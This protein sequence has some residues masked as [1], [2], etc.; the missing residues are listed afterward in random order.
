M[1]MLNR[2]RP[3]VRR[4][5]A[6]LSLAAFVDQALVRRVRLVLFRK[7][8]A[9]AEAELWFSPIV[10]ARDHA[11]IEFATEALEQLRGA[12]A[13]DLA[14][15]EQARNVVKQA[16]R[17]AA[18]TLKLE[19]ELI[20]LSVSGASNEL[21]EKELGRAIKA[22]DERP[23]STLARWAVQALPRFPERARST[24]AAWALALGASAR[25]GSTAAPVADSPPE[26]TLSWSTGVLPAS[27]AKV[28]VGVRLLTNG[29]ELGPADAEHAH[30]IAIP[31]TVPRFL[32]IEWTEAAG[33]ADS[34]A[35]TR[36]IAWNPQET[37]REIGPSG[38]VCL[39]TLLGERFEL[40]S[41]AEPSRTP[42]VPIPP[43]NHD[44]L[45]D[46][47]NEQLR[48][49]LREGTVIALVAAHSNT[50]AAAIE[51]LVRLPFRHIVVADSTHRFEEAHR[52]VFGAE[53]TVAEFQGLDSLLSI[54]RSSTN[55]NYASLTGQ[56]RLR[57]P[58]VFAALQESAVLFV[59]FDDLS[60]TVELPL[61]ED[62]VSVW[63]LERRRALA[64]CITSAALDARPQSPVQVL[65]FLDWYPDSVQWI[66]RLRSMPT[67]DTF[68]HVSRTE[69]CRIGG[70]QRLE[71]VPE[72]TS[73][74]LL[75]RSTEAFLNA[76]LRARR[77]GSL[78]ALAGQS[79][80]WIARDPRPHD[81]A[82]P[83][84]GRWGGLPERD[85]RL[86]TAEVTREGQRYRIRL[87]VSATE[88]APT[89][90]GQVIFHL[91][92]T[93][94]NQRRAVRVRDGRAVLTITVWGWFTVG[95]ECDDGRTRLELDLGDLP[96][97]E[98]TA[99][100]TQDPA[101]QRC[102]ISY[103]R[104][105]AELAQRIREV[106]ESK[107]ATVWLDRERLP[108]Q[109]WA[110]EVQ[111][112]LEICTCL[113]VLLSEAAAESELVL[114]EVE[115]FRRR[116]QA[117]SSLRLIPVRIGHTKPLAYELD[118]YLGN[119]QHASWN[120]PEDDTSLFD[121]LRRALRIE[122][123]EPVASR[124]AAVLPDLDNAGGMVSHD[125]PFY[126]TRPADQ[127][128]A[129]VAA[130]TGQTIII[131]APNEFGKSSA[132]V[133]YCAKCRE[134][135]QAVVLLDLTPLL[136]PRQTYS[137]FLA[138]FR[139]AICSSLEIV[140]DRDE[141]SGPSEL[142]HFMTHAVLAKLD[143]PLVIALDE[144]DAL[145]R[146]DF[147]S[148]F[149]TLLRAF[150]NRR[151]S[152]GAWE[153]LGLALTLTMPPHQLI[154]DPSRSPFNIGFSLRL[155][156]FTL[157]DCEDLD[158]RHSRPLGQP[159]VR[160]IFDLLSGHP[161]LT[162]AA[163][164]FVASGKG[165]VD[166][167]YRVALQSAGPFGMHLHRLLMVV[168]REK[169][170]AGLIKTLVSGRRLKSGNQRLLSALEANGIVRHDGREWRLANELY[171]RF[172]KQEL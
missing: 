93:F 59:G 156:S 40:S 96:K 133:R 160:Q 28:E 22:M 74:R 70:A 48:K 129:D 148:E 121:Q 16:H 110:R 33:T 52:R 36:T 123:A 139:S 20:W 166:D 17:H 21:I 34:R 58:D 98:A 51:R 171:A 117:E 27:I 82:D 10:V 60:N 32:E 42:A 5:A 66:V 43:P 19:E 2:L 31:A 46:V 155:T 26:G 158:N 13:L 103:H 125:N 9:R 85:G 122:F 138:Q 167:L 118:T 72:Q 7:L 127:D 41:V 61:S 170:S 73:H 114:R 154:D 14:F 76:I 105:D 87:V 161:L 135:N 164:F 69:L 18:P 145:A 172:F 108:G 75:A 144:V 94:E 12:V 88:G 71:L 3:E 1:T 101:D 162:R 99:D 115:V 137:A 56:T 116:Q 106:L 143:R 165:S 147:K 134:A 62:R 83:Q 77:T 55:R 126:I 113:I 15:G 151:V 149:F 150:H 91:H 97:P 140:Q 30:K 8:D 63:N 23:R 102:F 45:A 153:K 54:L 53:P 104:S 47:P 25:L 95:A 6:A 146:Q 57:A 81:E 64:F 111:R 169:E 131:I 107:G 24:P 35:L 38:L 141:F 37:H 100:R 49:L 159:A 29:I 136:H 11:A 109:E 124:S 163:F 112:Q 80:M 44:P 132:L 79:V 119:L 4:F 120:G 84:R 65:D 86:V 39:C 89:L 142:M 152:Q 168:E 78:S 67:T 157:S 92:P 68:R 50:P 128:L 90:E 130:Q